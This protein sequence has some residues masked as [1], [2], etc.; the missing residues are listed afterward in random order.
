MKTK[1]LLLAFLTTVLLL[2]GCGEGLFRVTRMSVAGT[3]MRVT[4]QEDI[5]TEL[6]KVITRCENYHQ[7]FTASTLCMVAVAVLDNS[8]VEMNDAMINYMTDTYI[9]Y[10]INPEELMK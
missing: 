3:A 9:K 8:D 1:I 7:Y 2:S 5:I 6:E 4:V 10:G